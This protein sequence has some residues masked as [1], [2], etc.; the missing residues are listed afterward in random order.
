MFKIGDA[1]LTGY[2]RLKEEIRCKSISA[3]AL[4]VLYITNH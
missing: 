4:S 1:F 3:A 2:E